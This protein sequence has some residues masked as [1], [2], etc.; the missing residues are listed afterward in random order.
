MVS[1]SGDCASFNGKIGN[2]DEKGYQPKQET[3]QSRA[4]HGFHVSPPF[5]E[6]SY[7]HSLLSLARYPV[8]KGRDELFLIGSLPGW[9]VLIVKAKFLT[10][11]PT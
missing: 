1:K 7:K 2:G 3:E 9:E 11:T 4:F 6:R 5:L 10:V 8:W